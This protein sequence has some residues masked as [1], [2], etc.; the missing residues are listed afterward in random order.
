MCVAVAASLVVKIIE[1]GPAPHWLQDNFPE[2]KTACSDLSPFY[3][4]QA[5]KIMKEWKRARQPNK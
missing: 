1:S 3:L 4:Q 2:L 5:R